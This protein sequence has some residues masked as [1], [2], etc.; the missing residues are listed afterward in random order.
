[1]G[2]NYK[3]KLFLIISFL[4]LGVMVWWTWPSSRV[5]VVFCDVGQGDGVLIVKNSWQMIVDVGPDNKKMVGCLERHIPFWD[6]K[7]EVL[8]ISHY[9]LDHVG[10]L[11]EVEKYYDIEQKFSSVNLVKN[12]VI[13]N[14]EIDFEVLSPDQDWQD[15]N[16]NS[17]VGVLKYGNNKILFTGDITTQV[18]Q[19]L[20][21]RG[22]LETRNEKP[23]TRVIKISHHGS[24][25]GTSDELLNHWKPEVA[26]ISVGKN[27]FGHPAKEVLERLEKYQIPIWRTDIQGEKIIWW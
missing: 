9:D 6:K 21:W 23:E 1:M 5:K 2:A 12:D 17:I 19:K 10:G 25:T 24:N 4:A 8:V 14:G 20:V 11:G 7:I 16:E 13:S 18:E 22:V 27:S 15:D 26:I 3:L